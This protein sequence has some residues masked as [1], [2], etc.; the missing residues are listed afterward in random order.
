M[1]SVHTPSLNRVVNG[2]TCKALGDGLT[3]SAPTTQ[4]GET[5]KKFVG[6]SRQ[7]V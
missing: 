1:D 6:K 2:S 5:L 7:I 3:L 4:N